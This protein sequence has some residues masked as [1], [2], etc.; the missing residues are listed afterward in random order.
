MS[1]ISTK[2]SKANMKAVQGLGTGSLWKE[3]LV[4]MVK[5]TL[6]AYCFF[7]KS[8]T[9]CDEVDARRFA[10]RTLHA[11]NTHHVRVSDSSVQFV[12]LCWLQSLHLRL[13]RPLVRST[14]EQTKVTVCLS[15]D[16][17][18]VL[19]L[20]GLILRSTHMTTPRV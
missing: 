16:V 2:C 8:K 17:C 7:D 18:L 4:I 19:T 12:Q 10:V 5:K 9:G 11:G 1:L 13:D 15:A 6:R 3:G 14:P 20:C